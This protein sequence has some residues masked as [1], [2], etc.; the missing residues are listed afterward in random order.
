MRPTPPDF[1]PLVR[2][3]LD[4]A[5][6][7]LAAGQIPAALAVYQRTWDTLVAKGDHFHASVVAHMAGVAEPDPVKK[8]KWNIAALREADAAPDLMRARGMY[9]SLYN[10]LGMSDSITGEPAEAVRCFELAASHLDEI[11][12]GPYADQ[13]RGG[14]ERNRARLRE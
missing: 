2:S 3:A 7:L 9:S 11:G 13:V 5:K 12:P 14:I 10:N 1:D 4:E 8:H 6:A